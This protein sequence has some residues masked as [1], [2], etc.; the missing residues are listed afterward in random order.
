MPPIP[1]RILAV[2]SLQPENTEVSS[3]YPFSHFRKHGSGMMSEIN[4]AVAAK[5]SVEQ[6]VEIIRA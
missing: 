1:N 4:T 3:P 2:E 5:N 6:E